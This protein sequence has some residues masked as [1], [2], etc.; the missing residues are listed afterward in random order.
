[1]HVVLVA[2]APVD[3]LGEAIFLKDR[4]DLAVEGDG[5]RIFAG[6]PV[7]AGDGRAVGRTIVVFLIVD[8]QRAA[9]GVLRAP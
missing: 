9:D 4:G 2:A 3:A 7:F 1:M 5:V 8:V 6:L